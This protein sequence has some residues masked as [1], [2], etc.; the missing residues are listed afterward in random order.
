M[1]PGRPAPREPPWAPD[2]KP[3]GQTH[4]RARAHQPAPARTSPHQPRPP[5]REVVPRG[6]AKTRGTWPPCAKGAWHPAGAGQQRLRGEGPLQ[7]A[8]AGTEGALHPRGA[9]P[10]GR[11]GCSADFSEEAPGCASRSGRGEEGTG[12]ERTG[13]PG[14]LERWP[15]PAIHWHTCPFQTTFLQEAPSLAGAAERNGPGWPA[16]GPGSPGLEPTVGPPSRSQRA[17][18]GSH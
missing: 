4:T 1:A 12:K 7:E 9:T 11:Q 18:P 2:Q 14:R 5:V 17:G 10:R 13:E 6:S 3:K 8:G 15:R 16:L